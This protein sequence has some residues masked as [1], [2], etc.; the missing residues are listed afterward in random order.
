MSLNASMT[1]FQP[2]MPPCAH[3]ESTWLRVQFYYSFLVS[4]YLGLFAWTF[5]PVY[6]VIWFVYLRHRP[7]PGEPLI[8]NDED[9]FQVIIR[10]YGLVLLKRE[11]SSL[12]IYLL[13]ASVCKR[14]FDIGLIN[15][16]R[17]TRW[18]IEM[19]C[20]PWT[21]IMDNGLVGSQL[22]VG[23]SIQGDLTIVIST[24]RLHK[25]SQLVWMRYTELFPSSQLNDLQTLI[26]YRLCSA[27]AGHQIPED[28]PMKSLLK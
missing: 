14:V 22:M 20:C 17:L 25:L 19:F 12:V 1:E 26:F 6:N 13:I 4:I 5:T 10:R 3:L 8:F 24:W 11:T 28:H 27:S 23:N 9:T 18:I 7:C 2:S 21:L 15:S 16:M